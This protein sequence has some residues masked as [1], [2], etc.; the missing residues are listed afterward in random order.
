MFGLRLANDCHMRSK[1][2]APHQ[3][4][5]GVASIIWTTLICAIPIRCDTPP[6]VIMSLMAIRKTG[7]P[8]TMPIFIRRVMSTSSGLG[9]SDS[10]GTI[11][12]S[13]LP[14]LGQAPGR[15]LMTSG[16]IGHVYRGPGAGDGA[17]GLGL[18]RAEDVRPPMVK[19]WG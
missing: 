8:S 14:H 11:G 19:T 1:N 4:T 10:V 17:G 18:G 7:A 3:S 9:A 12:S 16:C 13:A 6:P 5:T 2:G 15:A